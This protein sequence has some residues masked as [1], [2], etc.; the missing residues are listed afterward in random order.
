M[1]LPLKGDQEWERVVRDLA[2]IMVW[3]PLR[4]LIWVNFALGVI[5]LCVTGVTGHWSECLGMVAFVGIV[6]LFLIYPPKILPSDG[7]GQPSDRNDDHP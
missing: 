2:R 1:K 3:K 7:D 5:A 6:S 4:F